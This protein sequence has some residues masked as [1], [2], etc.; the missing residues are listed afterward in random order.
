MYGTV[1]PPLV[2]RDVFASV[3]TVWI[4]ETRKSLR[5]A[6]SLTRLI[7]GAVG[8]SAPSLYLCADR[9]VGV[10][11]HVGRNEWDMFVMDNKPMITDPNKLRLVEWL[12][13]PRPLRVPL[14]QKELAA[15]LG[16]QDRTVRYWMKDPLVRAQWE[17]EA[18]RAVGDPGKVQEV[19]EALRAGALD[20]DE[21]LSARVRAAD[22]YLKAV[23]AIRPAVVDVASKR[24]AEMS[25]D[26]LRALV[27]EAAQ[28][29]LRGRDTN[30]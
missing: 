29:E 8:R 26:E 9:S 14:T 1:I 18:K 28:V 11:R 22:V 30:G 19:I 13:T 17:V 12:C 25:D 23:D 27:A 16:V 3:D 24:A 5:F 15:E 4:K 20:G 10:R 7:W 21:S 2:R 6:S